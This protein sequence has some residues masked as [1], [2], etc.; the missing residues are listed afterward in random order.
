MDEF[1]EHAR[2]D[3]FPKMKS[4]AFVLSIMGEPDPKLCLEIGAA[5]MFNKPI[6]VVVPKGCEV[7]LAL[8]TIAHKIVDIDDMKNA[9]SQK[10]FLAAVQEMAEA[11]RVRG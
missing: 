4:S 2:R 3:M 11:A 5:I 7:P 10:T 9:E 8:R 1:L 6:L